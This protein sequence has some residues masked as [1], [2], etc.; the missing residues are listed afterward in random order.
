VVSWLTSPFLALR[1]VAPFLVAWG[2]GSASCEPVWV[3]DLSEGVAVFA[4]PNDQVGNYA[5][6]E[7]Y[8]TTPAVSCDGGRFAV[9]TA[10]GCSR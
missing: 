3:H 1:F 4:S 10:E 9:C 2:N 8:Y 5:D 7:D 6:G